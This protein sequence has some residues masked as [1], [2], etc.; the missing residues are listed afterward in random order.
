MDPQR[1][2]QKPKSRKVT[3]KKPRPL[4]PKRSCREC[5]REVRAWNKAPLC[6][7]C[8]RALKEQL[9][10]PHESLRDF[11]KRLND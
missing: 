4:A 11:R 10:Q 8:L 2:E 5:G 6:R 1:Q 7:G 9:G 3:K